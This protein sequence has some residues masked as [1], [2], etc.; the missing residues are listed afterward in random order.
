MK[1]LGKT[2]DAIRE[3]LQFRKKAKHDGTKAHF[4]S[5]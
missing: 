2:D 5:A 4:G 3:W 1:Q